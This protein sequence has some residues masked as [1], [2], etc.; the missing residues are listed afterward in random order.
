MTAEE[1]SLDDEQIDA[2]S[3]ATDEVEI[4]SEPENVQ[5]SQDV[6]DFA[7]KL[8]NAV[9]S[10]NLGEISYHELVTSFSLEQE[11]KCL[12]LFLKSIPYEPIVPIYPETP[13][14]IFKGVPL[15]R[16]F[17]MS[18]ETARTAL[19][20]M[21]SQN[22]SY[23]EDLRLHELDPN[24]LDAYETAIRVYNDTLDKTRR[25]YH[26]NVKSAKSQVYEI[27]AVAVCLFVIILVLLGIT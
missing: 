23:Y 26:D 15:P 2:S 3:H 13:F 12:F 16:S 6:H 17:D 8:V 22:N 19:D 7:F 10:V 9:K 21:K 24:Y 5:S 27:S 1:K 18:E 14:L 11:L 20:F 4:L 25:S